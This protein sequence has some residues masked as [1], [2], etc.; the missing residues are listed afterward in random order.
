M[1]TFAVAAMSRSR[2]GFRLNRERG[3]RLGKEKKKRKGIFL[4]I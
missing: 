3:S 4:H 2:L 1:H